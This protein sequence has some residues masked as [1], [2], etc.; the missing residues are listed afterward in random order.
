MT[1]TGA[2]ILLYYTVGLYR[3]VYDVQWCT[4]GNDSCHSLACLASLS[5]VHLV[6]RA[7]SRQDVAKSVVKSIALCI[8]VNDGTILSTL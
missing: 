4:P 6:A 8:H 7:S 1:A 2:I 5:D 3:L